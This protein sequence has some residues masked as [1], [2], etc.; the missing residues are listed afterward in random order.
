VR[1]LPDVNV[2]IALFDPSHQHHTLAKKEFIEHLNTG[3]STCSLVQNGFIRIV[4]NPSY[5]NNLSVSEATNLLITAQQNTNHS[6]LNNTISLLDSN[7]FE[8]TKL[9]SHKQV[10]DLFLIGMAIDHDVTLVTFDRNIP[11]HAAIG[12]EDRHLKVI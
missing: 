7:K 12:F 4:S 5:L 11:F 3:W 6:F 9:V 1:I 10:T 8:T 2:L